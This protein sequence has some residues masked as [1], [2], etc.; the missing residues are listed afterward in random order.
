MRR[1]GPHE[2][3]LRRSDRISVMTSTAA[4]AGLQP[5]T[6]AGREF[7]SRLILGT[8]KYKDS[9]TMVAAL[10]ASGT[11]MVTVALRRVNLDEL[12]KGAGEGERG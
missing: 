8:G 9:E 6:L 7:R 1:S 5:F 3:L 4:T 10:E 12:G 2:E 11:E